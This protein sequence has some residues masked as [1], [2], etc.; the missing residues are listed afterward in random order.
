MLIFVY[1]CLYL[2]QKYLILIFKNHPRDTYTQTHIVCGFLNFE[3]VNFEL[4][5]LPNTA[6]FVHQDLR[7]M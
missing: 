2:W 3:C 7:N 1:I 6:H 4:I 5:L